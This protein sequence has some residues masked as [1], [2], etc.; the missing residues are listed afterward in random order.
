V[1]IG[2]HIPNFTWPGGPAQLGEQLA[3]V[4]RTA[5]EVGFHTI[6]VMDHFFQIRHMGPPEQEM[7][8]AYTTLGFLA[9]HTTQARLL[10]LVTGV[11]YRE[12]AVLAKAVTT[13][14]VLAKGRAW[15]GI[16]AAW[17]D[18]E[19]HA[20]GIPFPGTSERF[21][22]LEEALQIV[23]RMWS[24]DESEL[25]GPF[26]TLPRPLNSPQPLTKP[27]PPILIGGMGEQKTLRLVAKYGDACNLFGQAGTEVLKQKLA[28]LREHC[29]REGRNFDDIYKTVTVSLDP[30]PDGSGV[31]PAITQLRELAELGFQTAIISNLP[32]VWELRPLEIIGK[33]LIPAIAD[34]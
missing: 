31:G 9:A 7:L 11:I 22:R 32:A 3:A 34:F 5:D 33:E 21:E 1:K 26:H 6:S 4:A 23:L 28:V 18:E 8:E 12:P 25:R 20:L 16:G 29:A 30:G 13:L 24:D 27:H 2:L 10:T 14:D 17:N 15:L 19:S